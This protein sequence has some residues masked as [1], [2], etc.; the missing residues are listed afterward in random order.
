MAPGARGRGRRTRF[1]SEGRDNASSPTASC[2]ACRTRHRTDECVGRARG[3]VRQR[4][5][6]SRH[7]PLATFNASLNRNNAGELRADLL[8]SIDLSRPGVV[9]AHNVAEIIQR[10]APDVVPINEFDFDPMALDLFAD[11][12][13]AVPHAGRGDRTTRSASSRRPTPASSP[14]STSTTTVSI[15][16]PERRLR[17]RALPGSVRDGRLLQVPDR[18][19]RRPHV[20]DVPAGRTCPARCSPTTRDADSGDWYSPEELN[21]FRLSSKSHWDVPIQI[22][23]RHRALPRQPSDAAGLR[24][25][26]RIATA[27]ATTTRSASGPTTSARP[28]RYIYDDDGG[29]A[30]SS[31]APVRDRRRPELRPA[32]GDRIP[33]AIQQLL[34]HPS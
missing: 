33:G 34:D 7:G 10:I 23:R 30:G 15:G 12:F 25:T 31:P 4:R 21:V 24:R 11:R 27:G 29:A 20:P 1:H 18:R 13:L 9:Q 26:P 32:R 2:G 6:G 3:A 17:L 14:G 16:G 5:A 19:R 28:R 8:A 22:G